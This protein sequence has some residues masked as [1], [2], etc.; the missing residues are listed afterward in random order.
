VEAPIVRED[1]VLADHPK[2]SANDTTELQAPV[3]AGGGDEPRT[4]RR[5]TGWIAHLQLD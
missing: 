2:L 5:P 4:P 3:P 1:A